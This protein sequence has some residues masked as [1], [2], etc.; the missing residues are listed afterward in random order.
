ME[1]S[2]RYQVTAHIYDHNGKLLKAVRFEL[3]ADNEFL[4]HDIGL[5]KLGLE[6]PEMTIV[7]T[8]GDL[9]HDDRGEGIG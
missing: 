3:E 9:F 4:A 6:Y 8:V 5:A 2:R 1:E 7:V